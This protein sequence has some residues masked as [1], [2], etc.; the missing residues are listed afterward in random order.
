MSSIMI[1][2]IYRQRVFALLAYVI[3]H[4]FCLIV[5]KIYHEE[6]V[7]QTLFLCVF[8]GLAECGVC[9]YA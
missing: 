3:C 1:C 6:S 5:F 4:G 2:C 7:R 9:F 8:A